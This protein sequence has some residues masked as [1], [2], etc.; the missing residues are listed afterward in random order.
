[1]AKMGR[2]PVEDPINRKLSIK[3]SRKEY[4]ALSEF[5]K[6]HNSSVGQVV[7][8]SVRQYLANTK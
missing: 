4:E 3:L 5:A 2:P 6:E 1:M 8:D 7:R